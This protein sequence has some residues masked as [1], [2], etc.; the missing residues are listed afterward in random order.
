MRALFASIRLPLPAE[1][2]AIRDLIGIRKRRHMSPEALAKLEHAR[3]SIKSPVLAPPI[4]YFE[5]AV[6]ASYP[7]HLNVGAGTSESSAWAT[8][9]AAGERWRRSN[10]RL[11]RLS[12][13]GQQSGRRN[14]NRGRDQEM[15]L[16]P[17]PCRFRVPTWCTR[18]QIV[19]IR[20]MRSWR[21]LRPPTGQIIPVATGPICAELN[22]I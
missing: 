21:S 16:E 6:H 17:P 19:D 4:R 22:T 14:S 1:A 13:N 2:E 7:E 9:A 11:L 8:S 5:R 15:P 12:Q 3:G 20:E 10:Q 18:G